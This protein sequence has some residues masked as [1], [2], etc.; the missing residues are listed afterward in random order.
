MEGLI[1][2]RAAL[3]IGLIRCGEIDPMGDPGLARGSP[4]EVI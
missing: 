1:M 3:R 4:D 2:R